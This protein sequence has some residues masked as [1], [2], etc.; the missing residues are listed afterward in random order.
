[1]PLDLVDEKV[2]QALIAKAQN[3]DTAAYGKLYDRYFDQV[4]RYCAF[5]VEAA[6]AEDLTADI[7]VKAWEK[8]GSY[9]LRKNVPFGAW[10]FRIARNMVIDAYRAQKMVVEMPEDLNDPD[11]LNRADT[12]IKRKETIRDVRA[13]MAKLPRRYQEILTLSFIAELP[14]DEISRV[15][16]IREGAVRILKF[17]ALKKLEEVLPSGVYQS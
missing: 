8:I 5:R 7:F 14:H 15:L 6:V 1:M 12:A 3:G 13:A 16:R 9:S 10:L 2:L 11:E 17:R 4:Y